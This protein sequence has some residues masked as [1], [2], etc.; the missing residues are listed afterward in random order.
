MVK[1]GISCLITLSLFACSSKISLKS[2]NKTAITP[3]FKKYWYSNEAEINSYD[4]TQARYGQIRKGNAF[5]IFVTEAFNPKTFV[6]SDKPTSSS[7]SVLKLN[8]IK[9]FTTGIYDYSMMTSVFFPINNGKNSLKI[10]SSSQEWCGQTYLELLNKSMFEINYFSYFE[11]DINKNVNLKKCFL[12]DDL[13]NQIRIDTNLLPR[14]K[15]EVL[16][17]FFYLQLKH[18]PIE[19]Q[20]AIASIKKSGAKNSNYTIYYPA[21]KRR[22]TIEF[23]TKFPH[24]INAWKESYPEKDLDES[25]ILTTEAKLKKSIKNTYW[26]SNTLSDS[27]LRQLIN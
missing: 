9:K 17:S 11:Q 16:P 10:N 18:I 12:E 4:L 15:V 2:E 19:T 26:K 14:G 20:T 25:T 24:K 1:V 8:Y 5:L 22:L 13:F 3:H 7:K 21:L 6:K 27:T 23:E